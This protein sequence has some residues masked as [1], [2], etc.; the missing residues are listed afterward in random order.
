MGFSPYLVDILAHMLSD[1][2]AS[3]DV[4]NVT[5]KTNVGVPQLSVLSPLL[6]NLFINDL[7]SRIN[8]ICP[9]FAYADELGA[10]CSGT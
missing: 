6:F 2:S 3:I 8:L 1:T 4:D 10:L 7:L 5:F 9:S